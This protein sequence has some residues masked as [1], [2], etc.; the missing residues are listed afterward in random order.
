M[1][2][3]KIDVTAFLVWFIKNYPKSVKIMKENP[4]FQERFK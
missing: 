2:S 1:L 3:E 4:E